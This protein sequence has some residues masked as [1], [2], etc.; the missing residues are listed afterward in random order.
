MAVY[1]DTT[2]FDHLY[3]KIGC[4][5]ADIANLRKK[6]YGREFSIPL[7]IH[8]LEEILLDRKAR[9]ELLVARIKLTLSIG[10]LR[11]MVKPCNQLIADDLRANAATGEASHP[12][13]GTDL[14]NIITTGISE[15]IE[16]DGEDLDEDLIDALADSRRQKEKFLAGIKAKQEDGQRAAASVA[17]KISFSEYFDMAAPPLAL[18]FAEDANVADEC[19]QRGI[20]GLLQLRSIRM[21]V[22]ATLSLIYGRVSEKGSPV[23]RDSGD[24][25][26]AACA[27]AVAET[28]VTD[29]A[30]L[31][32]IIGRVPLEKFELTDLPD[33][34]ARRGG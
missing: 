16:S 34:L 3:R 12:F 33:F 10:N 27:A 4:T 19:M 25:I 29:D 30:E 8:T 15:L 11:R 5:S 2:A 22:G 13:I 28:F 9:P 7:S 21:S 32:R 23:I 6:I 14:Q 18:E 1:L 17:D 26:H 24:L 31:R 20:E